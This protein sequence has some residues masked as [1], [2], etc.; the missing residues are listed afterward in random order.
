MKLG[1]KKHLKIKTL[2]MRCRD[3]QHKQAYIQREKK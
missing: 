1:I 3:S 2:L